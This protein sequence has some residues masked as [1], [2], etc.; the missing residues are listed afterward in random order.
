[1]SNAIIIPEKRVRKKRRK[2]NFK[3]LIVIF[4]ISMII[5]GFSSLCYFLT[6][7]IKTSEERA[8]KIY[9][10]IQGERINYI[11][12]GIMKIEKSKYCSMTSARKIECL[13]IIFNKSLE[14]R[15]KYY[16]E[17]SFAL[18]HVDQE[19]GFNEKA[20]GQHN[21]KTIFQYHP[22]KIKEACLIYKIDEET[23]LNDL[24]KQIDFYYVLMTDY[25][26]CYNG[27]LDKALLTYNC[28]EG[29]IE[30]FNNDVDYLKK[31]VYIE[32]EKN[33]RKPYSDIIIEKYNK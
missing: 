28:G 26:K 17:P 10:K 13:N 32:N 8:I 7:R 14:Y 29:V 19:S 9:E 1:M 16:L 23:F 3:R 22:L 27:N 18:F 31:V 30:R 24:E 2:Y 4:L 25:L 11:S 33:P 21:E 20:I 12:K 6:N 5:S 15:N